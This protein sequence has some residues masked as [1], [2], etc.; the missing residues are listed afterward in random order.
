MNIF[1]VFIG[2][3]HLDYKADQLFNKYHPVHH[4]FFKCLPELYCP[5]TPDSASGSEKLPTSEHLHTSKSENNLPLAAAPQRLDIENP[6]YN[7][8]F[9]EN[10]LKIS[11][12]FWCATTAEISSPSKKVGPT[13]A[14]EF[15]FRPQKLASTSSR[16]SDYSHPLQNY[17][18]K[19]RPRIDQQIL[20]NQAIAA[21]SGIGKEYNGYRRTAVQHCRR[22]DYKHLGGG[23]I[24][25]I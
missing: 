17:S 11:Q 6:K 10:F 4:L 8:V 21:S 20:I 3:A 5:K 9:P 14:Y 25:K 12:Q 13:T 16:T 24:D 22:D 15:P 23:V 2:K 18:Y 19:S 7:L 1:I